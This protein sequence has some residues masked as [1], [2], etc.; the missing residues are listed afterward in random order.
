MKLVIVL[1]FSTTNELKI[2]VQDNILLVLNKRFNTTTKTLNLE[3]FYKDTG[4]YP[5]FCK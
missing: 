5:I 4:K 1:M 2:N 3:Q